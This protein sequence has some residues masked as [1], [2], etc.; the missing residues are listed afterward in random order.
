[1]KPIFYFLIIFISCGSAS[2]SEKVRIAQV[3]NEF[4]YSSEGPA[5]ISADSLQ[6]KEAYINQW[7]R[8]KLLVRAAEQQLPK[9]IN[10]DKLVSDYRE[11]LLMT[12]LE[13]FIAK[14]SLDTIVT[15]SQV[16]EY[17]DSH[18][19][20]FLLSE[21]AV[22]VLYVVCP[23]GKVQER[24]EKIWKEKKNISEL[25]SLNL[26]VCGP[27]WLDENKWVYSTKLSSTFPFSWQNKIEWKKGESM[28]LAL[29]KSHYYLK[30]ID[31]VEQRKESPIPLVEDNIVKII[32]HNR[33]KEL[34]QQFEDKLLEEGVR[35]NQIT[36]F[37]EK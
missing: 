30:I 20:D 29:E 21:P 9:T 18:K 12:N 32:L 31:V 11:S 25:T 19:E 22:K 14:K 17:F 6:M 8:R 15:Q 37:P 34:L 5:Y 28:T 13:Q 3:G 1:M 7:I 10:L 27:V 35:N 24:I 26:S 23:E 36:L 33:R 16:Q 2:E 4:L